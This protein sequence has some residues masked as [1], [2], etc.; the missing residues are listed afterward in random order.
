M[1]RSLRL[2]NG[3]ECQ[4][5]SAFL[6]LKLRDQREEAWRSCEFL[7]TSQVPGTCAYVDTDLSP[8]SQRREVG[9][10]FCEGCQSLEE[11]EHS[12]RNCPHTM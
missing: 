3:V 9:K 2:R 1:A 8:K 6:A 7:R 10:P 11:F 5:A 4:N 12:E